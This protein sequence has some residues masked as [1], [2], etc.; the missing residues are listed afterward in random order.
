MRACAQKRKSR[1]QQERVQVD[2]EL[3]AQ[4]CV[5]ASLPLLQCVAC[6]ALRVVDNCHAAVPTQGVRQR[7][8]RE[9]V[10]MD[11]AVQDYVENVAADDSCDDAAEVRAHTLQRL[12]VKLLC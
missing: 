1:L 8:V 3:D 9:E 6:G 2:R 10:E 11:E 7:R 4:R 5:L 12:A